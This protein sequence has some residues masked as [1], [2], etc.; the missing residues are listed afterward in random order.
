MHLGKLPDYAGLAPVV[1]A[2]SCGESTLAVTVYRMTVDVDVGQVLPVAEIENGQS[3]LSIHSLLNP[4]SVD[5]ITG[6]FPQLS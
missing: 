4:A 1:H 3:L 2:V 6:L 5:L